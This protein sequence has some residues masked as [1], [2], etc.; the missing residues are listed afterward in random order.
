MRSNWSDN[1][2]MIHALRRAHGGGMKRVFAAVALA[3]LGGLAEAQ[4]PSLRVVVTSDLDAARTEEVVEIPAAAL[5]AL[6]KPEDLAKVRVSDDAGRELIAQAVDADGDE[7]PD[8]LV[9][10]ADFAPR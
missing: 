1:K 9:F 3:A 2:V 4:T 8:Q 7:V 6:A 5:S 10:L